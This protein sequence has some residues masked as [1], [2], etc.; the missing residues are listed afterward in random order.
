MI[1]FDNR[2][3]G[4]SSRIDGPTPTVWQKLRGQA[5]QG[6]YDLGDMAEDAVA[7]LDHL[8]IKRAHVVGMS[9]GGMIGQVVAARYPERTR[10]LTSIFSTTGARKFGQPSF[11]AMV[12]FAKPPATT[13]NA[14]VARNL[15]MLGLI[16]GAGFPS[17]REAN[18]AL[19]ARA[20]DRGAPD[21]HMAMSRQIGAI[22]ASGDRTAEVATIR[23]PTLVIH[24]DR[25]PLVAPSGG[26]ATAKAIRGARHVSVPGMGHEISPSLAPHLAD[27]IL[28]HVGDRSGGMGSSGRAAED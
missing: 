27:L 13:R 24:G 14:Y 21:L 4:R 10:T 11:W 16:G 9:M 3:S 18:R 5:P 2:D 25:D 20:W 12:Q 22:Y 7:L 19:F 28:G 15:Q 17:D 26:E 6:A 1:T 23:V 8:R